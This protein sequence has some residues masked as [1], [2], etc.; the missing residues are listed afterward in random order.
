MSPEE[1]YLGSAIW[2]STRAAVM[3]ILY[4][5]LYFAY[6]GKKY[7]V[8][9]EGNNLPKD[10]TIYNITKM[11]GIE[12]IG[13]SD[14][15]SYEDVPDVLMSQICDI[16]TFDY[17]LMTTVYGRVIN[18]SMHYDLEA[19]M[20]NEKVSD[21]LYELWSKVRNILRT[22]KKEERMRIIRLLRKR[23]DVPINEKWIQSHA[24][25]VVNVLSAISYVLEQDI[26]FSA[27]EHI[28]ND[29]VEN[30]IIYTNDEADKYE[31]CQYDYTYIYNEELYKYMKKYG[32]DELFRKA[33]RP[34]SY[35]YGRDYSVL[36]GCV[37]M[38][39]DF[40]YDEENCYGDISDSIGYRA[41]IWDDAL[42]AMN[43]I[44]KEVLI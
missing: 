25:M 35:Y 7:G 23:V 31:Y 30:M 9:Y 26:M 43:E 38:T 18:I 16:N 32:E 37:V 21:M 42:S 39:Y 17:A 22:M 15:F 24:F 11:I 12:Q 1:E 41:Y 29:I 33:I 20:Y 40:F 27:K 6:L 34:Y 44:K 3:G 14:M 5:E 4:R 19:Y 13:S 10:W 36:D 2:V 8:Q 28:I